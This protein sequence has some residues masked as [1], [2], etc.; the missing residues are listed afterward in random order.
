[1]AAWKNRFEPRAK[2][3]KHKNRIRKS[4]YPAKVISSKNQLKNGVRSGK[5]QSRLL[6]NGIATPLKQVLPNTLN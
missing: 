4:G 2:Y 3:P 5:T 1:M 6:N